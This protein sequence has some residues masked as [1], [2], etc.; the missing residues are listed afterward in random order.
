MSDTC[1]KILVFHVWHLK[2]LKNRMNLIVSGF[3]AH[4]FSSVNDCGAIQFFL[5]WKDDYF[6]AG[7]HNRRKQQSLHFR[8]DVVQL[9]SRADVAEKHVVDLW[10]EIFWWDGVTLWHTTAIMVTN[11][12][13]L[14]DYK[15]KMLKSATSTR[16]PRPWIRHIGPALQLTSKPAHP[17]FRHS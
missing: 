8:E 4:F 9:W 15:D 7:K 13:H 3:L 6:P 10:S 14:Q 17:W 11:I 12:S 1:K 5:D 2:L 16:W